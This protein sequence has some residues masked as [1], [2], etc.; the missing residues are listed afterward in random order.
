MP[1]RVFV[2]YCHAQ[3]EWVRDRLVPCLRAA[4]GEVLIDVEHFTAGRALVGQMDAMQ[5]RAHVSVLVLSPEY[6]ASVP[7]QHEMA[8]A[9]GRDPTFANGVTIPIK[10]VDCPI[11][12]EIRAPDP[13]WVDL[14]DDRKAD[15][16]DALLTAACEDDL[17]IDAPDWLAARDRAIALFAEGVSFSVEVDGEASVGAFGR[18]LARR[19]EPDVVADCL[20]GSLGTRADL[21]SRIVEEIG[22]KPEPSPRDLVA[23]DRELMRRREATRLL[24]YH[25]D[26]LR[27]REGFD[28]SFF[29]ALRALTDARK[30]QLVLV[31]RGAFEAIL[32]DRYQWVSDHVLERVELRGR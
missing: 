24:L 20:A 14:R 9:I 28:G 4:G 19:L 15:R 27:S 22:G 6:L 10:R 32:P 12:T 26:R 3:G 30:L 29:D 2:S 21:V 18:E 16:W 8:R 1:R 7:C 17:R 13:L 25:A 5:D 11:P 31:L 23:L